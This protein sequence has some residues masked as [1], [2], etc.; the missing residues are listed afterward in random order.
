MV[1]IL[2]SEL[3]QMCRDD[4]EIPNSISDTILGRWINRAGR[5]FDG[6]VNSIN[7]SWRLDSYGITLTGTETYNLAS[8][9]YAVKQVFLT[10]GGRS[11]RLFEVN[12]SQRSFFDSSSPNFLWGP[13]PVYYLVGNT[14]IN[15]LPTDATGDLVVYY[16]PSFSNLV[17]DDDVFKGH[18][19]WE[20]WIITKVGYFYSRRIKES[21]IEWER[22]LV[23]IQNELTSQIATINVGNALYA[24]ESDDEWWQQE[25]SF[26]WDK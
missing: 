25:L 22:D 7:P 23:R 3:K 9:T 13:A 16:V 11:R 20:N 17:N 4:N 2:Y 6:F 14:S 12:L 10:S 21:T 18:A 19:G 8:D 24:R 5:E 15:I 1:D 26:F